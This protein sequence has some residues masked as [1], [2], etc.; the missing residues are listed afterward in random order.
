VLLN[1]FSPTRA[2]LGKQLEESLHKFQ[3][4]VDQEKPKWPPSEELDVL[5]GG[6]LHEKNSKEKIKFLF[7][8]VHFFQFLP[9]KIFHWI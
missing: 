2:S 4:I 9:I 3:N 8:T 1:K 7:L 5:I 6:L